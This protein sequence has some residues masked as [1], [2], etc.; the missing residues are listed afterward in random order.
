SSATANAFYLVMVSVDQPGGNL[1]L[2]LAE[3]AVELPAGVDGKRLGIHLAGLTGDAALGEPP[4]QLAANLSLG[5][6]PVTISLDDAT[7]RT[8]DLNPDDGGALFLAI[9]RD[10]PSPDTGAAF[11]TFHADPKLDLRMTADHG[12]LGDAPFYDVSQILLDGLV[13]ATASPERIELRSGTFRI[14]TTPAG[15]GFDASAGQCITGIEATAPSGSP[16]TQWTT[17]ACN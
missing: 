8:I 17:G 10:D 1:E 11:D 9:D 5:G 16:F 3:T 13:R 6:R 4:L 12:V 15:H 7:A 14:D 2:G